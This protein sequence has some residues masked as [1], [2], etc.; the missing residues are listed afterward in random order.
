MD[1]FEKSDYNRAVIYIKE[2]IQISNLEL[3]KA[4]LYADIRY[5]KKGDYILRSGETCR[6]IGFLN[7]GLILHTIIDDTGKEVPCSFT[8]DGCFFTYTEGL[9]NNEPS[10]KNFIAVEDCVMLILQK[11]KLPA[12]F[13]INA[14]FETLFTKLLAEELR[15]VL[16]TEQNART[17]TIEQRYLLFIETFPDAFNRMPLKYVAGYLGIEPQSLSRLRK[18]LQQKR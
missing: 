3:E 11:E 13:A 5:F 8:P 17:L 1:N 7:A 4:F 9:A 14:K 15:H 2:R 12:L 16:L 10:H 18:K 6:F